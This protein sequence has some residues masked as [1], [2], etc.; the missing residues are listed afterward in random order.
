MYVAVSKVAFGTGTLASTTAKVDED[1]KAGCPWSRVRHEHD[2]LAV[3]NSVA[4]QSASPPWL[5]KEAWT[6][7]PIAR[8]SLQKWWWP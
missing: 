6:K 4:G 2:G 3:L 1:D 7:W 5:L 8:Q